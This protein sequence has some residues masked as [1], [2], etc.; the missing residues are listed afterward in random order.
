MLNAMDRDTTALERAFQLAGSGDHRSI[1]DIKQRLK[2]EGYS[3][4]RITGSALNKQLRTLIR[5]ARDANAG[6][7]P[8][9]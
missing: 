4:D 1:G 7:D 9:T 8:P 3:V 6:N 5:S 2:A